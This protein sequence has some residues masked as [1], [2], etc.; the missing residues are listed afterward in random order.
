MKI[1]LEGANGSGKSTL[2]HELSEWLNIPLRHA[3]GPSK[4][5]NECQVRAFDEILM[6]GNIILD[7]IQS[8]SYAVYQDPSEE[9]MEILIANTDAILNDDNILIYC[10]GEGKPDFTGK[11][12]YDQDLIDQVLNEQRLIRSIYDEVMSCFPHYIYDFNLE[13]DIINLLREKL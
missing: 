9:E 6:E 2:G 1:I 11:N 7:R 4:D 3:G 13:S 8:I 10:V 12:Y 5:F